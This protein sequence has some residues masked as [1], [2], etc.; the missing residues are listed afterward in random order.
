[1][2]SKL[3]LNTNVVVVMQEFEKAVKS[4]Y[5]FVPG[6]SDLFI[7]STGLME[8]TVYKQDIEIPTITVEDALDRVIIQTH[9]KTQYLLDVQRYVV[10]GWG[11]ELNTV[12]FD[13]IG[14]KVCR[15]FHPEHPASKVYSKE[16]LNEMSWEELKAIAK[17][18]N[19]FNRGKEVCVNNILK[20]QEERE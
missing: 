1:M 12:Y 20:F 6:R 19:C 4:G 7:H 2:S 5:Y 10:N 15:L 16:E 9:D 14:S 11:V 13:M 8:L 18:R 3:I 17:I